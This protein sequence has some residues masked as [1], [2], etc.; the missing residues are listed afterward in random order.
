MSES[1]SLEARLQAFRHQTPID[2]RFGDLDMLQ[3]VNNARYLSYLEQARIQYAFDVLQ[4]DG[5]WRTLNMMLARVEVDYRAPL[6]LNDRLTV[7]TRCSR[8]GNKSFTLEYLLVRTG[9]RNE[10][11][12]EGAPAPALAGEARTVLVAYDVVQQVSMPL[13]AEQRQRIEAFEGAAVNG[14]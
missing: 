2:I 1:A 4:W 6:F 11:Q 3:H 12:V 7:Y 14:P 10:V 8:L 9:Q 5:D 13:P